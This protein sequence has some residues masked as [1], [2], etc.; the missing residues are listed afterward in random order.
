MKSRRKK[1]NVGNVFFFSFFKEKI[2][3]CRQSQFKMKNNRKC[4]P[5]RHPLVRFTCIHTTIAALVCYS[6]LI[7]CNTPGN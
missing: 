2:T 1:S 5:A 6:V 7:V 3:F 4:S